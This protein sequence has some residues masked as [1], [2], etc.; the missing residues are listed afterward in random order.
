MIDH[1]YLTNE[2]LRYIRRLSKSR[3]SQPED[4]FH[5]IDLVRKH[6]ERDSSSNFGYYSW[7]KYEHDISY[8]LYHWPYLEVHM[9]VAMMDRKF[10]T[11]L[12]AGL[13]NMGPAWDHYEHNDHN[14][15]VYEG[16]LKIR[17]FIPLV[18]NA[19]VICG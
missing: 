12:Y 5:M 10:I 3:V 15:R 2:Q 6:Y 14:R 9:K 7:K 17:H 1:T 8:I 16:Y 19:M 11:N 18:K 13:E 4:I